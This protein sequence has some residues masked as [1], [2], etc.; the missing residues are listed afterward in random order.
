MYEVTQARTLNQ[1]CVRDL[2]VIFL[3]NS[4]ILCQI[5]LILSTVS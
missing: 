4:M 1:L 3:Q 2:I 5:V